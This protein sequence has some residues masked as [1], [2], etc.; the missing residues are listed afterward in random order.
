MIGFAPMKITR[1]WLPV[2]FLTLCSALAAAQAPA[3]VVLVRHAEKTAPTGDVSISELGRVRAQALAHVLADLNIRSIFVTEFKRTK[4]T[5][6]PSVEKFHV[7]PQVVAA[8]EVD[9]LVAKV[10]ATTTGGVALVVGHS[11]TV[12]TII[13]KL[14][15]GPVKAIED[16][17][18]DHLYIVTLEGGKAR[19]LSLRFGDTLDIR[20]KP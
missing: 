5:A 18:Y 9:A 16:S 1:A 6:A 3:T 2:A 14:G 15:A 12:P 19:L 20:N 11:N 4:E 13:E 7:E 17:E 10:R 8:N